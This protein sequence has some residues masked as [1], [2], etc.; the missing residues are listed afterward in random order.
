M[1]S[2]KKTGMREKMYDEE[3]SFILIKIHM[4]LS[5]AAFGDERRRTTDTRIEN[6]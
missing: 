5:L 4:T 1:W 2:R 3:S 6:G